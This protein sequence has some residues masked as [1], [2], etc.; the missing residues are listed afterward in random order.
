MAEILDITDTVY[1]SLEGKTVLVSGG[2]S[3]IGSS[4]VAH[5]CA[6]KAKVAF[7]DINVE[8]SEALVDSIAALGHPAPRFFQCDLRD[9]EKY[10]GIIKTIGEEMG[11]ISVLI[12]N[13]AHDERHDMPDVTP[14]YWDDRVAVNMKHVFFAIQAVAPQ[15]VA[16]GAGS[17]INFGSIS[18]MNGQADLPV[19]AS[20]KAS[21]HGLTRGTANYY[22]KHGIRCNT[23]V[24]GWIFTERQKELWYDEDGETALQANQFLDGHIEPWEIARM[25]LFLGSDDS[26]MCTAQNFVVDGGWT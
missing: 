15:M 19:Y 26:K 6:Q 14:E 17:I 2:G 18:W 5:Y 7:V 3:G 23:I 22:G 16:A 4:I 10:Q 11:N 24:P 1:P 8:A 25:A 12:N 9:I 20:S 21:I 13:A